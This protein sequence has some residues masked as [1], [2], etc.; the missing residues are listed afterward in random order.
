VCNE[1][2]KKC[3]KKLIEYSLGGFP[4]LWVSRSRKAHDP[5]VLVSGALELDRLGEQRGERPN[6]WRECRVANAKQKW[7]QKSGNEKKKP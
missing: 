3:G 4:L 7:K 5:E 2:R 6:Q 1:E